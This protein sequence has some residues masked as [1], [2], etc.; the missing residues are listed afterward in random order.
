MRVPPGLETRAMLARF[1]EDE[2]GTDDIARAE[3]YMEDALRMT[4]HLLMSQPEYQLG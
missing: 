4:L 3:T 2:L 1:L